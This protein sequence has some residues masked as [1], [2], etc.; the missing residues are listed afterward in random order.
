METYSFINFLYSFINYLFLQR[1]ILLTIFIVMLAGLICHS[2]ISSFLLHLVLQ[3]L[4]LLTHQAIFSDLLRIID[5][6]RIVF[7]LV[8]YRIFKSF[9]SIASNLCFKTYSRT[10]LIFFFS[11]MWLII[12][13]FLSFQPCSLFLFI[14]LICQQM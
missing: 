7:F 11:P 3:F 2:K 10:T 8:G 9:A 12:S 1:S 5:A 6:V 4:A 14:Q 13:F